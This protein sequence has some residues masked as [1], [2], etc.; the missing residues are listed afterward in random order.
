M[1]RSMTPNAAEPGT[2]A[3]VEHV[4]VWVRDLE[5]HV[6]FFAEVFAMHVRAVDVADGGRTTQCWTV[7]GLQLMVLDHEA[8]APVH[9]VAHLGIMCEDRDAAVDRAL[10]LGAQSLP[11]GRHWLRLPEGLVVEVLQ[12]HNDA[13][14][15]ALG[16]EPRKR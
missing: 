1:I 4:A 5:W 2:R 14:A 13:V 6:R 9:P 16:I 8:T 11:H 3:Y 12:A 10:A 7:G 15:T